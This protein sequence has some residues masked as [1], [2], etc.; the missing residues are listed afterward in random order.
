M[1]RR[2]LLGKGG[3]VAVHLE[4]AIYIIRVYPAL[5]TEKPLFRKLT[6]VSFTYAR[7]APLL[8]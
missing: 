7:G 5:L 1:H 3:S 8:V 4:H 2:R 6:S